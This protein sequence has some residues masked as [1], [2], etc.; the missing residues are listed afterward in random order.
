MHDEE[1]VKLYRKLG[2]SPPTHERHLTDEQIT[3]GMKRL[4]PDKWRLEGNMLRGMT[5]MGELVLH[6]HR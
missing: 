2:I 1:E 5:E 4:L 3:T 6:T